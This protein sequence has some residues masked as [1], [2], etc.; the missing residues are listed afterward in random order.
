LDVPLTLFSCVSF[1]LYQ[2]E[3]PSQLL[4]KLT[5]LKTLDLSGNQFTQLPALAFSSLSSLEALDLSNSTVLA[6]SIAVTFQVP[7]RARLLH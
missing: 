1:D 6:V 7:I 5:S 2:Q 4:T 3:L